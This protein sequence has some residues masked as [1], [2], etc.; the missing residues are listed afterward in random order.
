MEIKDIT[1][2]D[3]ILRTY[4]FYARDINVGTQFG[5]DFRV[6]NARTSSPLTH[7]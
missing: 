2:A 1:L 3:P 4:F 6:L 5:F 7:F